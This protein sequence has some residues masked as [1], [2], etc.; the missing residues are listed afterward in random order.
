MNLTMDPPDVPPA[1]PEPPKTRALSG[2][3]PAGPK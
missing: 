2:N 1:E 3:K